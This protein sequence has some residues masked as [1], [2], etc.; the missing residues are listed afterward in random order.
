MKLWK[1]HKEQ[2]TEK[3]L[4][5]NDYTVVAEGLTKNLGQVCCS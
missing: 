3:N 5:S 2:I 4:S 1:S